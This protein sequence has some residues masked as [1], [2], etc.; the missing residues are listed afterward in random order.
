MISR[1]LFPW[2]LNFLFAIFLIW[3]VLPERVNLV[4]CCIFWISNKNQF[5][6]DQNKQQSWWQ[7]L[8]KQNL[9]NH[10]KIKSYIP[11]NYDV[12]VEVL[13]KKKLRLHS[14]LTQLCSTTEENLSIEN[15]FYTI[16][17]QF[18]LCVYNS[19]DDWS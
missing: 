14:I 18:F 12:Y 11:K 3:N 4:F 6:G 16:Y 10:L 17:C 19:R 5:W 2:I 15:E 1:I 13:N 9:W 8:W 7:P